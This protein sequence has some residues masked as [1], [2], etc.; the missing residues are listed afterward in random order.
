MNI[1]RVWVKPQLIGEIMFK[2]IDEA[3]QVLMSR[4]NQTYGVDGL[5]KALDTVGTGKA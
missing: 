3:T 2:T 5:V 4:K 1:L